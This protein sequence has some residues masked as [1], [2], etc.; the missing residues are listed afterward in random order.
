MQPLGRAGASAAATLTAAACGRAAAQSR[1]LS[2]ALA[3]RTRPVVGAGDASSPTSRLTVL[4][5]P[6]PPF[7]TPACSS[8]PALAHALGAV[9]AFATLSRPCPSLQSLP[10]RTSSVS[11][12]FQSRLLSPLAA[13][14]AGAGARRR[15]ST[16]PRAVAKL[17]RGGGKNKTKSAVKKR[18]RVNG[19]GL[20]IR[21]Q[22][23]KR[24]LNLSKTRRRVNE[25]GRNAAVLQPSIR[26]RYLRMLGV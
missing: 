21:K 26:K 23:G 11:Y 5:T 18:F 13:L 25:L 17:V 9:A 15:S 6:R 20:L 7:L 10:P 3:L 22:S 12:L 1:G 14:V 2:L 19:G 16:V 8:S 24:H 4:R